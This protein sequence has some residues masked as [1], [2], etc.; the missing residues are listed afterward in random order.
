VDIR[1]DLRRYFIEER[2]W[3]GDPALLTDEYPLVDNDVLDSLGIFQLIETIENR[4]GVEIDEDDIVIENF[5][6][7]GAIQRLVGGLG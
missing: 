6:T 3:L 7:I 5:G 4:Y 2:R 1:D